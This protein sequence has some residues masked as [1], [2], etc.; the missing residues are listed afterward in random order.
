MVT[1][2]TEK[3]LGEIAEIRMCKRIFTDQTRTSGDIPFYKIGTFGKDP[4]AYISRSIYE[5]YKSKYSFPNKGDIL[6]S[7]AGT[8]GRTV[9][10]DGKPGYFQDSNI[11]WL[12]IDKNQICNEY[13]NHYYLVIE[14]ASPEGSTIS[15]LYNGIIRD[16][17]IKFP[18]LLSEQRTIANTLSDMERYIAAL[19]KLIAK[20]HAVKQ[21]VMQDL[22]TGKR[23]LPE[24][25][26]DFEEKLFGSFHIRKGS[27]ITQ[28]I[29]KPGNI[30]VVAG[31][32][33]PAYY[34][35]VFNRE[36]NTITISASGANAGFVNFWTVRIFAS[37]CSTIEQSLE[38]NVRFLYYWLLNN[39]N[40][41]YDLQTGGAQ[42]HV[43]PRDLSSLVIMLPKLDEQAAIAS[44]LSDMDEEIDK[45]TSKLEKIRCIKQGMI[46]ELLTGRIRLMNEDMQHGEN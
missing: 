36:A 14:W 32:K 10:Y 44:I 9:V 17:R 11:V 7:A 46:N 13:L 27:I 43:Q 35:N 15:R 4:D 40:A 5:E 18:T 26:G 19:E 3:K 42:P 31:G 45:L 20:K 38:Y 16:T 34:H 21:G 12:E 37:D 23:R 28:D 39:Q 25:E 33:T 8:L 24:F 41:I 2:W 1:G 6:L 29:I 22:L 30:P